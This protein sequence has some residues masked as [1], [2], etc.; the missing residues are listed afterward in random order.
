[1]SKK[2]SQKEN[3]TFNS[4]VANAMYNAE[5]AEIKG[6]MLLSAGFIALGAI[7]TLLGGYKFF[8]S[9]NN[10]LDSTENFD[11]Y[12]WLII[13]AFGVVFVVIGII[14]MLKSLVN[15]G[16]LSSRVKSTESHASPFQSQ[17]LNRKVA[18][19]NQAQARKK[20]AEQLPPA[21]MTN[22]RI[23]R[24]FGWGKK[25]KMSNSDLYDMYNSAP[26]STHID[27]G[28]SS[29]PKGPQKAAPVMEQ[30]FDYGIDED[31]KLTFADEFLQKNKRDPFAQ[32]RKDLGIQEEP[33]QKKKSAPK[34]QF[35]PSATHQAPKTPI[36]QMMPVKAPASNDDKTGTFELDLTP[37]VPAAPVAASLNKAAAAAPASAPSLTKA[38]P[39]ASLEKKSDI[40][41]AKPA[42]KSEK[43]DASSITIDSSLILQMTGEKEENPVEESKPSAADNVAKTART[44]HD[45]SKTALDL[46]FG[47][48][49]FFADSTTSDS[50][51][52]PAVEESVKEPEPE[53]AVEA[54]TETPQ[55]NDFI[56]N[57]AKSLHDT[58][59]TALDLSFGEDDFF[60]SDTTAAT[61]Q[62]TEYDNTANNYENE[63]EEEEEY[64]PASPYGY[65][66][67]DD[68]GMFF[69]TRRDK[70][71][72][73]QDKAQQVAAQHN[74]GHA[75][76]Y[77][78][79]SSTSAFVTDTTYTKQS[80]KA[81]TQ[82]ANT[83]KKAPPAELKKPILQKPESGV[84]EIRVDNKFDE[85]NKEQALQNLK[86][87]V[88]RSTTYDF[89]LFEDIK[90]GKAQTTTTTPE[91]APVPAAPAP[92]P[93]A[94]E[95]P[96]RAKREKHEV[97]SDI[98]KNGTPA[99]RKYVEA[100]EF[101]EWTCP[102]CGKVNQEYVAICACGRRKPRPRKSK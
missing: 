89:S 77:I 87:K 27:K 6:S 91:P 13:V 3:V 36:D 35:I 10:T 51:T 34:P 65:H 80:Q 14:S 17:K 43:L 42:E 4:S 102:Q 81:S 32:Y 37:S 15:L 69:A 100:S 82:Q 21:Q 78:D 16:Q 99:Q 1:M 39:A 48:D 31:K 59:K 53:P 71:I 74:V 68:D 84:S 28:A 57:R 40:S 56:S 30:K 2:K 61:Q 96:K 73:T 7:F 26:H 58:S 22:G 33:V 46:S 11:A 95:Q 25:K 44:L 92:A 72:V 20:A 23:K 86:Q 67:E 52:E 38:A 75:S 47:D 12:A 64:Y 18:E 5:R 94:P 70:N 55:N 54:V 93:Q 19:M 50:K 8:S 45:T 79:Y 24:G 62:E 41:A 101:D 60:S 90:N 76:S 63:A 88:T 98:V 83:E 29:P 66:H 85:R 97:S 49:D 9:F